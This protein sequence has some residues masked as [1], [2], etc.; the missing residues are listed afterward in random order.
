MSGE[1]EDCSNKI[2]ILKLIN[3]VQKMVFS[4]NARYLLVLDNKN[5]LHLIKIN[6]ADNEFNKI[7]EYASTNPIQSNPIQSN[8]K[9]FL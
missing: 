1:V 2:E 5:I 9:L 8:P 6:P 4:S 7:V 3:P